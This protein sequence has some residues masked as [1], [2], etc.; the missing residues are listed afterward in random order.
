MIYR[1]RCQGL[2]PW[3]MPPVCDVQYIRSVLPDLCI[4]AK[5]LSACPRTTQDMYIAGLMRN[6]HHAT[7]DV[8]CI[9]PSVSVLLHR[10]LRARALQCLVADLLRFT[11][12]FVR[13]QIGIT[14]ATLYSS[15]LSLSLPTDIFWDSAYH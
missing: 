13:V 1:Q 10:P 9:A 15:A 5:H 11:R 4:H 2:T 14:F 6:E 3:Y 8:E 12:S 7:G